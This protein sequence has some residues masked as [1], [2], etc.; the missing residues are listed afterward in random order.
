MRRLI[1][2]YAGKSEALDEAIARFGSAYAD[3]T[4]RDHDALVNAAR[5]SAGA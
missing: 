1:A 4:E 2:R 3:Q 5:K